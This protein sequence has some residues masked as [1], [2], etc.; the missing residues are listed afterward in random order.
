MEETVEMELVPINNPACLARAL[1]DSLIHDLLQPLN[2]FGL[3]SEQLR[4]DLEKASDQR[5]EMLKLLD[6]MC[7]TVF[8]EESLL[9]SL[10]LYWR[11][12]ALPHTFLTTLT[13][14]SE[15]PEVIKKRFMEKFPGVRF[16]VVGFDKLLWAQSNVECILVA[17]TCL[18]ENAA[19]Y[20]KNRVVLSARQDSDDIYI[21][22][23]DDGP[24][25]L[26]DVDTLGMP[27]LRSERKRG[28]KKAGLGLGIFIATSIAANLGHK[29]LLKS[30]QSK[31]CRLS[32][33][34]AKADPAQSALKAAM[35]VTTF[36]GQLSVLI[37][38]LAETDA[39]TIQ[40]FTTLGCNV[41]T[42]DFSSVRT[43]LNA[44]NAEMPDVLVVDQEAWRVLSK[45]VSDRI[46]WPVNVLVLVDS[47]NQFQELVN[48]PSVIT[49]KKL[50]R[51]LSI[52]RLSAALMHLR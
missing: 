52:P 14:L 38:E 49:V 44:S 48:V 7:A 25:M 39:H 19:V 33:V 13:C 24:G 9:N 18:I 12:T 41:R 27:F 31:G 36:Y 34:L 17:L 32:L 6:M 4:E 30:S 22:V 46:V 23:L 15:I 29:L 21:D 3:L 2:A 50:N 10:R 42:T 51:P 26:C 40:L 1:P 8:S 37:V 5:G 45:D 20:G 28:I 16:E 47:K 35:R 43:L 11:Y